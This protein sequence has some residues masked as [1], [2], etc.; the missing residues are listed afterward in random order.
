MEIK[1]T[2]Q[3]LTRQFLELVKKYCPELK[4][5]SDPSGS[6]SSVQRLYIG[7]I[8]VKDIF[9]QIASRG[10]IPEGIVKL[11]VGQTEPFENGEWINLEIAVFDESYFEKVKQIALGYEQLSGKTVTI[12]KEY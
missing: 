12:Y 4:R 6:S 9:D 1:E 2:E 8:P 11:R 7:V 10:E 5:V 3:S